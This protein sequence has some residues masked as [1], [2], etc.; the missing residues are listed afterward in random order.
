M[1]ASHAQSKEL[2]GY[3]EVLI[4]VPFVPGAIVVVHLVKPQSFHDQ[5]VN[6]R[7]ETTFAVVENGLVL[8]EPL[9]CKR[10]RRSIAN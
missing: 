1:V 2:D 8:G 3:R 10:S 5:G 4:Q 9:G 6:T 7:T